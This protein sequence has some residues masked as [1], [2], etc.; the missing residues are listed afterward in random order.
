MIV[1]IPFAGLGERLKPYTNFINKGLLPYKERPLIFNIIDSYP[2]NY[3]FII[4]I[5][6]GGEICKKFIQYY[7]PNRKIKFI[8]IDKFKSN[9]GSLGYI[10]LSIS[11]NISF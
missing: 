6:Y 1:V 10:P 7:Y 4:G 2:K 11:P 5:G 9:D 3:N 8:K